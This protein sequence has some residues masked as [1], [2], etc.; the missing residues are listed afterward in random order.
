MDISIV[1]ARGIFTQTLIATYSERP[2]VFGFLRSFFPSVETGTKEI[3]I[4]VQRGTEKIA[5]DVMRG[6]EGNRNSFSRSTQKVFEPPYYKE[7]FDA[8]D[9]DFY[10]MLFGQL[11]SGQVDAKMFSDWVSKVS[12]K[13]GFLQ[14]KIERRYEV[15]CAQVI[16]DGIVQLDSVTNI[17]FKRKAA[18]LINVNVAGDYW[19]VA[20][21]DPI[22]DLLTGCDF[23]RQKGKSQGSTLNLVMGSKALLALIGHADIKENADL[24]N[25]G[26]AVITAPQRNAVGQTLHGTI[27]VGPYMVNLWSYPEFYDN[28]AGVSTPYLSDNKC[29]LLP[30]K[31]MFKFAFGSVPMI[32]RDKSNAEFAGYITQNA[33]AFV[34]G[35]YID[36]RSE[37][38]I[39]DIKSAGI[40]IPV[41]IDQMYTLEVLADV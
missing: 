36:D 19:N 33:S 40:A 4:E 28:A 10:D 12:E 35:N 23:I 8:T 11:S 13:I 24:K 6:T 17:D 27:S 7:W 2:K 20:G 39:F 25:Y 32:V 29:T 18:S 34:I 26:L 37:K 41:A 16:E 9:L 3:S 1:Q 5:V 14:D 30:E 15:Q 31:P 22:G 21:S 38:H